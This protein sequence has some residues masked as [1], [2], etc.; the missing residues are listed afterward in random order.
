LNFISPLQKLAV[1]GQDAK[2]E[3]RY[4]QAALSLF[5]D[6]GRSC[7]SVEANGELSEKPQAKIET[8]KIKINPVRA[9]FQ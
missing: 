5:A 3:A 8:L 4:E 9:D 2:L 1:F 7:G 6:A